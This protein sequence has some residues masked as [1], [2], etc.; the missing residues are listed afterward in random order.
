MKPNQTKSYKVFLERIKDK[1]EEYKYAPIVDLEAMVSEKCTDIYKIAV[2]SGT[3][4]GTFIQRAKEAAAD[5]CAASTVLTLKAQ[6]PEEIPVAEQLRELRHQLHFL[7][8]ENTLLRKMIGQLKKSKRRKSPADSITSR[9]SWEDEVRGTLATP[10]E[11][12]R[13]SREK[14]IRTRTWVTEGV[15]RLD[16]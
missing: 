1:E 16:T 2:Q 11:T 4:K 3:M 6:N 14:S 7:R 8:H 13:L 15:S 10:I 12:V 5:M 9:T